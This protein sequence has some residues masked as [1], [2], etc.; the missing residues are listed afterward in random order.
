MTL[1]RNTLF[2]IC[3]F[4]YSI[5]NWEEKKEKL[6]TM[7]SDVDY[8]WHMCFTDF[9]SSEGRADY[10]DE[11]YSILNDDFDQILPNLGLPIKSK[12][13]WQLWSQKYK[14]HA[15]HG[16]H[17][18][19]ACNLSAV[20]YVDL[21]WRE[22]QG[23]TFYCPFPDPFFGT[24]RETRAQVSEGDILFFPAML[25]HSSPPTLSEYE[26]TIISFNIPLGMES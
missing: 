9:F 17:N 6:T 26:R 20:M 3:Y 21:H 16:P 7:L 5:P 12:D 18:H 14:G 19:G 25:L 4:K 24:I 1:K 15:Y 10:F 22:H 23:T 2:D 13:T 11:W 8:E